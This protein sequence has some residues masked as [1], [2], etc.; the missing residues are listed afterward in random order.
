MRIA[1]LTDMHYSMMNGADARIHDLRDDYY[2]ELLN[3]FFNVQADYYVSLGDLT[4]GGAKEEF[5]FFLDY[6]QDREGADNFVHVLGNHDIIHA[7]KNEVI[8]MTG[9]SRYQVIDHEDARLV[10]LDACIER[11]PDQGYDAALGAEGFVDNEQLDWLS[12]VVQ[13]TKQSAL[14]VFAHHPLY[15]T[16]TRSIENNG[17]QSIRPEIGLQPILDLYSGQALYINGHL[18]VNSIVQ[19]NRWTYIQTASAL[20]APGFRIVEIHENAFKVEYVQLNDEMLIESGRIV[21]EHTKNFVIRN[22]VF[23]NENDR[24]LVIPR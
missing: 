7:T 13:S 9:Q 23:G 8:E 20:L 6:M 15:G 5:A 10:F 3:Q 11:A 14:L 19:A 21:A 22:D 24:N 4:H 12:Q 2:R 1:V 18:H 17:R 16:T